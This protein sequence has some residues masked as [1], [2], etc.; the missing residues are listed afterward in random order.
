MDEH[1]PADPFTPEPDTKDHDLS[2]S[3][4]GATP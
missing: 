3:I 2:V 4:G 1:F